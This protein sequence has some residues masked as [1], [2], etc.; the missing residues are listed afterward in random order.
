MELRIKR[1]IY[2]IISNCLILGVGAIKSKIGAAFRVTLIINAKAQI[3][4][5][6][7]DFLTVQYHIRL[8]LS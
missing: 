2:I 5:S 6:T 3:A 7:N 8:I 1:N 4:S